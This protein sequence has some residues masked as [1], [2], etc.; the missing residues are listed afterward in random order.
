MSYRVITHLLSAGSDPLSSK[1]GTA[2]G[3]GDEQLHAQGNLLAGE[4]QPSDAGAGLK[5][6]ALLS[7]SGACRCSVLGLRGT[8]APTCTAA[9]AGVWFCSARH[10]A[11]GMSRSG[12]V[13]GRSVTCGAG[14]PMTNPKCAFGDV[15]APG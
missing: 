14:H 2:Q 13:R 4:T 8:E 3:G 11:A 7:R 9:R 15:A 10:Q 1:P 5:A 12:A 6:E